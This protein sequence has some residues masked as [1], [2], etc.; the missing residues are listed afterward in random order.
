MAGADIQMQRLTHARSIV[1][2]RRSGE[3]S[4]EYIDLYGT[5][6]IKASPKEIKNAKPVWTDILGPN[7]DVTKTK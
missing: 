6:N 5:H 2:P 4:K 3:L 7:F 1:Q